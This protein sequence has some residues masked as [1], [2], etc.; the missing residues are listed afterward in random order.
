MISNYDLYKIRNAENVYVKIMVIVALWHCHNG[1]QVAHDTPRFGRRGGDRP[2]IPI[3]GGHKSEYTKGRLDI[4]PTTTNG[5]R[6]K[7]RHSLRRTSHFT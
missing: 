1:D 6:T 3:G 7:R 5:R 2:W 4:R